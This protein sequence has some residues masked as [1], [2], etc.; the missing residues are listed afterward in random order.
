MRH[1]GRRNKP[2][3]PNTK[4]FSYHMTMASFKEVLMSLRKDNKKAD[5]YDVIRYLNE[6]VNPLRKITAIT[7]YG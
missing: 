6:T 2:I 7:F 4:K 1:V 5:R 3:I